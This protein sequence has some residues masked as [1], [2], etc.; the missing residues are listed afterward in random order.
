VGDAA[1]GLTFLAASPAFSET[2]ISDAIHRLSRNA[3]PAV[4][5]QIA[6]N[7][8]LLQRT[9]PNT[10][11]SLMAFIS[12]EEPSR[13]VLQAAAAA[14]STLFPPSP[15]AMATCGGTVSSVSIF[16]ATIQ[17]PRPATNAQ[18]IDRQGCAASV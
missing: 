1:N 9:A 13:A 10:M 12:P 4:R 15:A 16:T 6:V 17:L 8:H 2:S 5:L 11:W 18:G 14:I 7:L 3:E